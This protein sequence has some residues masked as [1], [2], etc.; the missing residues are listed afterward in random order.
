MG[1]CEHATDI[2][3]LRN[4]NDLLWAQPGPGLRL[5]LM[6]QLCLCQT[7]RTQDPAGDGP[8]PVA[9]G[10]WRRALGRYA[11]CQGQ[12]HR[13]P[14]QQVVEVEV[15]GRCFPAKPSSAVPG[16]FTD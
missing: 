15:E 13:H 5:V 8:W 10:L 14:P 1:W 11:K 6:I 12:G 2:S 9:R 4:R 16:L 3:G 7:A